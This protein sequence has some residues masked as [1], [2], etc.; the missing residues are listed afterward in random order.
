MERSNHK[1]SKVSS[2]AFLGLRHAHARIMIPA[3]NG[4][5]LLTGISRRT[6]KPEGPS[7]QAPKHRTHLDDN[8]RRNVAILECRMSLVNR[9]SIA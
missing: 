7:T 8:Y 5:L 6:G 4:D 1:V 3:G 2:A 9:S